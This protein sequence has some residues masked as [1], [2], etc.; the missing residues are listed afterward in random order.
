VGRFSNEEKNVEAQYL[1]EA[2]AMVD[3]MWATHHPSHIAGLIR[4]KTNYPASTKLVYS[5]KQRLDRL[6]RE[7]NRGA[8]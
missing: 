3:Q 5:L 7:R 8:D 6:D 4:L 1:D 2:L